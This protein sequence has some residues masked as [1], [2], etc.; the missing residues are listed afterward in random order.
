M[1][2]GEATFENCEQGVFANAGYVIVELIRKLLGFFSSPQAWLAVAATWAIAAEHSY[3]MPL[4]ILAAFRNTLRIVLEVTFF[5]E[6]A[7]GMAGS[8]L[9]GTPADIAVAGTFSRYGVGNNRR[10]HGE[11][12]KRAHGDQ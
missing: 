12:R 4:L 11:R 5:Q 2:V 8:P 9:G 10:A 7:A 1:P 6:A 3:F